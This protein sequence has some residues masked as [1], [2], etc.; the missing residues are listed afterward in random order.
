[1]VSLRSRNDHCFKMIILTPWIAPIRKMIIKEASQHKRA[2]FCKI[3]E[4][5][6][7][8]TITQSDYSEQILKWSY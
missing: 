7:N 8:N 2:P 5:D 1:M 3:S 6:V 4:K